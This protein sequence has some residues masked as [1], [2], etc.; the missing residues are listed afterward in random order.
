M[1]DICLVRCELVKEKDSIYSGKSV[2][3]PRELAMLL[4]KFL[5]KADREVLLS[6]NLSTAHGING[7]HIVSIGDL[8]HSIA[9]PREVFKA[10]ILANAFR[11]VLA[12]NHPS[13]E[14]KPSAEDIKMTRKLIE[15]GKL[16]EIEV[17]DHIIVG[18]GKYL[19][20]VEEHIGGF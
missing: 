18:D 17:L 20:F 7:I 16:L 1:E 12:H 14:I 11:I 13:G 9:H 10:A 3:G 19:S 6:I 15:C 2:N 4:M 8:Y 5:E